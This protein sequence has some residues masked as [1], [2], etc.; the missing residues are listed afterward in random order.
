MNERKRPY[1]FRRVIRLLCSM[2]SLVPHYTL[3]QPTCQNATR[4]ESSSHFPLLD[5]Q[6]SNSTYHE[7]SIDSRNR[8][9]LKVFSFRNWAESHEGIGLVGLHAGGADCGRLPNRACRRT[10]MPA[11]I[12]LQARQNC[13]CASERVNPATRSYTTRHFTQRVT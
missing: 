4:E 13:R 2:L 12:S 1:T 10:R 3:D 7:S 9:N 5:L 6:S 11:H 8:K